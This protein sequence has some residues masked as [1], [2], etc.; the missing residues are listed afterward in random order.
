MRYKKI[1][2]LILLCAFIPLQPTYSEGVTEAKLQYNKGI[3]FYKIGQY[4]RSMDAFRNAISLDP[5]YIDAY[6]NLGSILEYLGQDEAALT[7]FKQIVVRK[8]DDYDAVYKAAEL[9]KKLGQY[10][11]AKSFLSIIPSESYLAPKAKQLA[12]E[13]NTDFQTIKQQY[14]KTETPSQPQTNGIYENIPSP[15][16]ITTDTSGNL[17]VAGFSDNVIF[18]ITPNGEKIVYL[19][20]PKIKGPISLIS[21]KNGN[22]YIANYNSNNILK[23]DASGQITILLENITKP[24]GL[25]ISN[26]ILF[27]S[28]Q[29]SNSVHR[30]KL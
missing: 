3:D 9:S 17:Y 1:I 7:V 26:G 24:Y 29:G 25:H 11:K 28:S 20:D 27:I 18:K 5:N 19:K 16:G 21:D 22:I 30:Y 4:D 12:N 15:T 10:D 13:L 14:N 8:P 6:Y 2:I 23:A